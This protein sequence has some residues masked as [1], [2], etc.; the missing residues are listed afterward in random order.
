MYEGLPVGEKKLKI[1]WDE[2]NHPTRYERIRLGE[3]D[4]TNEERTLFDIRDV[5]EHT[6]PG[7]TEKEKRTVRVQLNV[8]GT[9]DACDRVRHI[10]I[11]PPLDEVLGCSGRNLGGNTWYLDAAAGPG[12]S[13]GLADP[14]DTLDAAEAASA[15]GDTIYVHQ[16]TYNLATRFDLQDGQTL[17]GSGVNA[18]AGGVAL[19]A[20]SAPVL[21]RP[22]GQIVRTLGSGDIIGISTSGGAQG[23]QVNSSGTVMLQDLGISGFSGNGIRIAAGATVTGRRLTITGGPGTTR[24]TNQNTAGVGSSLTLHNSTINAQRGHRVLTGNSLN[25]NQVTI[26]ASNDYGVRV[27]NGPVSVG[28][29]GNRATNIN[30][31]CET[32]ATGSYVGSIGFVSVTGVG[33][34]TCP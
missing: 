27:V 34:V 26:N 3:G 15:P 23:I 24:G 8:E 4:P 6:Y 10:T 2:E 32:N 1:W 16:G 9:S 31:L 13:G 18:C 5:F 19:P 21:S 29:A 22:T 28:G 11:G 25:L 14:F 12:G 17:I 30:L 7:V 20:T 33:P